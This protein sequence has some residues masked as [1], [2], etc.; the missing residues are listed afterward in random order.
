MGYGLA[1]GITQGN[2]NRQQSRS[3]PLLGLAEHIFILHD[4]RTSDLLKA[5]LAHAS[6]PPGANAVINNF[7]L[8]A[9]QQKQDL[10][11]QRRYA[12]KTWERGERP[13]HPRR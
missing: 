6:P 9:P 7:K 4:S 5:I 13:G 3:A 8:L 1:D 12:D 2:A 11:R 10:L